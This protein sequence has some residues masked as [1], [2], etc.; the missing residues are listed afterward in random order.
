MGITFHHGAIH[1]SSGVPFVTVAYREF[2]KTLVPPALFPFQPRGEASAAATSESRLLDFLDDSFRSHLLKNLAQGSVA[3]TCYV[4]VDVFSVYKS[5]VAQHRQSLKAE[6]VYVLHQRDAVLG[7]LL[8][9]KKLF[10]Y[11]PFEH[12]LFNNEGGVFRPD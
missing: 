12:V 7:S 1:D 9:E 4:F 5:A 3:V 6:E 11:S 10:Y 2:R 8:L